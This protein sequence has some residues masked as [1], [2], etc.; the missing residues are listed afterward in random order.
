MP[1]GAKRPRIPSGPGDWEDLILTTVRESQERLIFEQLLVK[2]Q[3]GFTGQSI[4]L[5]GDYVDA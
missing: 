2:I 1:E 5:S 4:V 3:S